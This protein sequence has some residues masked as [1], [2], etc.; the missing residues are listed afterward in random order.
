MTVVLKDFSWERMIG[1]VHLVDLLG[2]GL[3]DETWLP[4]LPGPLA[5]RLREVIE[6]WKQEG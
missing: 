6:S 5:D 2:V 1:A 3:L 4:R